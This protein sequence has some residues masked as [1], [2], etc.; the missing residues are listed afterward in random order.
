MNH[1]QNVTLVGDDGTKVVLKGEDV[2]KFAQRLP[3]IF[4]A[5]K[6]KDPERETM[7]KS[8]RSD[9]VEQVEYQC[10]ICSKKCVKQ[11]Q[12]NKHIRDVHNSQVHKCPDCNHIF[13]TKSNMNK[14]DC[15]KNIENN[16]KKMKS[17]HECKI[18]QEKFTARSSLV[19]HKQKHNSTEPN[20]MCELCYQ[21]F[22]RKDNVDA[23]KKRIHSTTTNE[24]NNKN[25][26]C[27]KCQ[28]NFSSKTALKLHQKVCEKKFRGIPINP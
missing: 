25:C 8:L 12:L 1:Y 19:R 9:T 28:K 23:H 17:D 10:K 14:H 13:S 24:Q 22:D 6:V 16:Q 27:H 20:F 2:S 21:K 18:C 15:K 7:M 26:Q 4:E 11:K 5:F 3:E